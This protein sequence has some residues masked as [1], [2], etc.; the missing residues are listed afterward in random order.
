MFADGR[1]DPGNLGEFPFH[2]FSPDIFAG[3]ALVLA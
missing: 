3:L 1:P 2:E